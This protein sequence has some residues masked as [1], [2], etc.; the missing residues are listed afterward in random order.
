VLSTPAFEELRELGTGCITRPT[1]KHYLGFAHGRR[2][3]LVEPDP[4][5][6]HLLYAYRVYLSGIHLMRTGEVVANLSVLND[7]IRIPEVNELVHRKQQGAEKMPLTSGEIALH[8]EHLDRL[9]SELNRAHEAS[10]LP[11]EPTTAAALNDF[12]VRLRLAQQAE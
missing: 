10:S 4:T 5:V 3:R 2:K 12:V 6:K 9:E 7:V 11:N 1:V 8:T